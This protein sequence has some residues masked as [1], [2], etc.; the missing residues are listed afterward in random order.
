MDYTIKKK[1]GSSIDSLSIGY[2]VEIQQDSAILNFDEPYGLVGD[3]IE[4]K[5]IK[6]DELKVNLNEFSTSDLN[7]G[8]PPSGFEGFDLPFFSSRQCQR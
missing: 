8:S 1:N 7:L 3:G 6:L 2:L 4:A 5:T